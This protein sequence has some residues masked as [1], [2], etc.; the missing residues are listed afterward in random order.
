M[1]GTHRR[2]VRPRNR[3]GVS[4]IEVMV[5]ISIAVLMLGAGISLL[6]LLLRVERDGVKDVWYGRS[7]ARLSEAWRKDVRGAGDGRVEDGESRQAVLSRPDGAVVTYSSKG[8]VISRVAQRGDTVEQRDAFHFPDGSTFRFEIDGD[9]R[10][11]RVVIR[12]PALP[13]K[14]ASAERTGDSESANV[15]AEKPSGRKTTVEALLSRDLRYDQR[16]A[17]P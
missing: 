5:V 10:F 9:P 8:H 3:R 17:T 4:I 14:G 11:A 6:H 13:Q 1:T 12:R 16:E 7:L 2:T 15:A